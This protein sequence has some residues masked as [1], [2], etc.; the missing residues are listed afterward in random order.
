MKVVRSSYTRA[1]NI[2]LIIELKRSNHLRLCS[3]FPVCQLSRGME[4]DSTPWCTGI[5]TEAA[6]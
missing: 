1:R 5:Q 6:H 3:N 4:F 2:L